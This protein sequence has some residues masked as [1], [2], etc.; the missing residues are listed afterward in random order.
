MNNR[1]H[2]LT[3]ICMT[4]YLSACGGGGG[5]SSSGTDES[6]GLTGVIFDS[7]IGNMA[8]DSGTHQGVTNADGEYLYE[9]GESVV[10]S[11]GNY[12]F[13]G[14]SGKSVLSIIDLLG[15]E[16][17]NEDTVNLARFLQSIDSEDDDDSTIQLPD[18]SDLDLSGLDFALSESDFEASP[19]VQETLE[20]KTTRTELIA[21]S[22][23]LDH[24][25]DNIDTYVEDG[26]IEEPA[27]SE[28][29]DADG[30]GTADIIEDADDD[31][32]FDDDDAFPE[33]GSESVDTDDDGV[34]NNEDTDDDNDDV[35]DESDAFPL[36]ATES[37]DSDSDG[38]GNNS[39]AFP[40]D[41]TETT[42]S[43]SD[44]T[45]D[46]SDA[47]PN[48]ES[49]TTDSDG[50]G[51]GDNADT[52]DDNDQVIDDEDAFPFDD[53]ESADSDDDGVGDNADT[54]DDN[55]DVADSSDAFPF[56]P[57]ESVDTDGDGTGN[58]AD[59]DDD[60][61]GV[62]DGSDAFPLDET[63]S[64]DTDGDG[65]GN[66]ADTDDDND[67]VDDADD[68]FPLDETQSTDCV[69]PTPT[70]TYTIVD[71][72]QTLCY[73]EITG[74]SETCVG[75]GQ[76]GDYEGNQPSYST[77]NDGGI[78]IDNHTGLMWQASSDTDGVDGLNRDDQ[79]SQAD[80]DSYC[81]ALDYGNFSD[82]R[83]PSTKELVSIYLMS[84]EDLSAK[85]GA[86]S[87]GT[88]VDTE[89]IEPFIDTTYFD[90]GYGDPD[91]GE[92]MIDGQYASSTLN[93]TQIFSG[94]IYELADGFFGVNFVDGHI[95]TYETD[96]TYGNFY[97][98]CVRGNTSYGA[99]SFTDNGN[100]TVSDSA[101]HLMWEQDDS[102]TPPSDFSDALAMC[103][104]STTGSWTDWRLPNM[105]ELH[106]IVDYTK[107]PENTA[108]PAVNTTY[109]NSTQVTNEDGETDWGA[110]WTSTALLNYLGSGNKGAYVTFGRGLGYFSNYGV[111]DVHGAGA[112]RSDGKT[113]NV[114]SSASTFTPNA[115][116]SFGTTGYSSGPQG[117][118]L[119]PEYNYVRCV[120][121]NILP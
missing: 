19:E 47:F 110:Y 54:D 92:R 116:S 59:T 35:A 104:A 82:W 25:V 66:N 17:I 77:C 87:N 9:E 23:A 84:G 22:E 72:N 63:E 26:D 38:V 70:Y 112:Q 4:F 80:A 100:S 11:L 43:D 28:E 61:D 91:A 13:S 27:V 75:E 101:T 108:S 103:E 62:D 115:A 121:D 111:V 113:D 33:D 14:V 48:D 74:N 102:S 37:E 117:D 30:D 1:Y 24:L 98:R 36:D 3:T 109:F 31:G 2:L 50:D 15:D 96:P 56:D 42:D 79:L 57:S 41:E 53:T 88:T 67:G 71:T 46:N 45:G 93:I 29:L 81:S 16:D 6:T 52:D 97:T 44:G 64:V 105:K 18:L 73:G 83:L 10:F 94:I 114:L 21:A 90:V 5:G 106:S 95:K 76:D 49:E 40:N 51:T 20:E 7:P 86:T 34:G 12:T 78:V 58:N 32:V 99:N 69:E 89:G 39:D 55:D 68:A 119:R 85:T 120:R 60:N 118:V 8:Y 107:S 65:T